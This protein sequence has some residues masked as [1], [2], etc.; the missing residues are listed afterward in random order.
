MTDT[1][2]KKALKEYIEFADFEYIEY[3][4]I[5]LDV[6]ENALDLIN[7]QEAENEKN[8]NIIRIADKTIE[9]FKAENESLK[10]EVERLKRFKNYFD[11]LYGQSLQVA[12]W[13][14][15]GNLEPLDNFIDSAI[16][17]MGNTDSDVYKQIKVEA[18]KECL[19]KI[20][21]R[22]VS[23]SDFYIMVKKT[24]FDNLLKELVGEDK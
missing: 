24:E 21:Q 20:E 8:E 9:T 4:S 22:D 19:D 6:L 18:Y 16:A 11:D 13:H 3:T 12:D 17:E 2:V 1:E 7:R 10:A 5:R 15:N 23:E 14:L